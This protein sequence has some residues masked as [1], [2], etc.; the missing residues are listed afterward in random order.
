MSITQRMTLIAGALVGTLVIFVVFQGATQEVETQT[1]NQGA[2]QPSFPAPGDG[3]F[4]PGEV[5]VGLEESATQADLAALNRRTGAETEEDLPRSDVNLVDLPPELPVGEAVQRYEASPDVEYAE[6][7]FLIF[8]TRTPDDTHFSKLWGLNNT[9]QTIGSQAG[10]AD[11]DVDAPEAWDT[12]TGTPDTVVAVIDE[13]MDISHPDLRNNVWTNPGEIPGNNLDDDANGYVDDVH[14]YDFANDDASVY[15]PDP[16]S[17][18]GDEHGTH[19]AGT[20]AAEGNNGTGVTG[21]NWQARI[22]ALKFLGPDGGSTVDAVEA[23]NYAVRNGAKISNNSWG[24]VGSPSRSLKDAISR[25]DDAGHLFVAAAGNGGADGIGDN[26]DRNSTKTNYPSSYDNANIIAV[27]ATDNRDRLASF[28]NYGATTVDLAAP[29]VNIASTLPGNGYGYYSGT[30]MATPH[31]T[32]AAALLR[33]QNPTLDDAQI[34]SA[35]LDSVDKKSSLSSKVLTG[36]RLNAASALSSVTSVGAT[37][38]TDP[39]ISSVKP[40]PSARDRTPRLTATVRDDRAELSQGDIRFALDG[41]ERS[42]FSYDAGADRVIF[43]SGRL[44]LGKHTARITATDDAGN[45]IT[46]TW[47]F[48]V[49]RR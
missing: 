24:Y 38:A 26:N 10:T 22:M 12:S 6:P 34:K 48:K 47:T 41:Q 32:G 15:D 9:G 29:G 1:E 46:R 4:V 7:N 35:I 33:S 17:G 45:T 14:G 42:T 11:A 28:S 3:E 23:I 21:V 39:T 31:V 30:S 20:I 40:S 49:I 2:E 18:K 37:D 8:P 43:D 16:I 27:A 13:G 25:A 19:V 5:I 36:G 44:S